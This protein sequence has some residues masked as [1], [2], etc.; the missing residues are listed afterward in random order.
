V[1]TLS[2]GYSLRP[3]QSLQS[4]NGV[5]RLTLE[6]D[7]NVVLYCRS[8]RHWSTNTVGSFSPRELIMQT[9]GNLVLYSTDGRARWSTH[10]FNNPGSVWTFLQN[11]SNQQLSEWPGGGGVVIADGG[12][13]HLALEEFCIQ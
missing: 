4:N 5:Y 10:T 3:G 7:G 13:S 1:K 11:P 2:P 9:D 8:R 6:Q 12:H